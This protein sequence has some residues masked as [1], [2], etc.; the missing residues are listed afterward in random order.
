[1]IPLEGG[2]SDFTSQTDQIFYLSDL[3]R[4]IPDGRSNL[5]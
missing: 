2:L 3:S 1:M 4:I 5:A